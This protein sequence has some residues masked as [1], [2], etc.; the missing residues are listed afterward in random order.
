MKRKIDFYQA[1]ALVVALQ[2]L[3]RAHDLD[4]TRLVQAMNLMLDG[5]AYYSQRAE[6][7]MCESK[8]N[9]GTFYAVDLQ[10]ELCTCPD[11]THRGGYCKH[12]AA[13]WLAWRYADIL[14]K[15]HSLRYAP[16]NLEWLAP[17]TA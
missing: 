6:S 7:W 2:E 5:N 12:L 3:T 15:A 16:E 17:V 14:A 9:P 13:C 1:A 10:N 4:H 8:T 11:R